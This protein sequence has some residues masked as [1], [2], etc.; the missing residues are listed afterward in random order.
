MHIKGIFSRDNIFITTITF[1]IDYQPK[2]ED[3]RIFFN[4]STGIDNM[5]L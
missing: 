5:E 2:T 4:A 1:I 3:M